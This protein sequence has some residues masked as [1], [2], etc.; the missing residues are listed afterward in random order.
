MYESY[1]DWLEAAY[2]DRTLKADDD[3]DFDGDP[4]WEDEE[5]WDEDQD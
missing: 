4:D 3:H 5:D 1:D 2:E